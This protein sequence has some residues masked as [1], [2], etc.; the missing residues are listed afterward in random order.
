MLSIFCTLLCLFFSVNNSTRINFKTLFYANVFR[1][2]FWHLFLLE[3]FTQVELYYF[4][5]LTLCVIQRNLANIA[6]HRRSIK[7]Y[8]CHDLLKD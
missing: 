6:L 5:H 7:H 1:K 8:V 2:A 3:S 4:F